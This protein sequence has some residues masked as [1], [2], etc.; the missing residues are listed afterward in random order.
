MNLPPSGWALLR[1]GGHPI[2]SL[3]LHS[4]PL[5]IYVHIIC[6]WFPPTQTLFFVSLFPTYIPTTILHPPQS[7]LWWSRAAY[8]SGTAFSCHHH[9]FANGADIIIAANMLAQESKHFFKPWN[10]LNI[11]Q[12]KKL[13]DRGETEETRLKVWKGCFFKK[14][15]ES[16]EIYFSKTFSFS[17]FVSSSWLDLSLLGYFSARQWILHGWFN[18]LSPHWTFPR[19]KVVTSNAKVN[20]IIS[21]KSPLVN[22][23]WKILISKRWTS[24]EH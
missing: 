6:W 22:I 4:S 17:H 10:H 3:S 20:G 12:L 15:Y 9:L 2:F 8:Q 18:P 21:G 1:L 5:P 24:N 19:K 16:L 7:G 14:S 13:E 11:N 23:H